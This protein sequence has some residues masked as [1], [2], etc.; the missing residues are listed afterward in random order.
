[1][2]ITN[3]SLEKITKN[4]SRQIWKIHEV[5][6]KV[7]SDRGPKFALRFIEYL[8]KAL[9]TKIILSTLYW[10]NRENQSR[11]WDI[12]TILCQL[13]TGQLDRMVGSGRIPVQ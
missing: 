12:I 1:V 13:P 9:G 11:N 4:L 8:M 7:L 3:V 6:W 5:P 2:I 10:T